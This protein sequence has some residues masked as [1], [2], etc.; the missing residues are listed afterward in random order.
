LIDIRECGRWRRIVEFLVGARIREP[1]RV[2]YYFTLRNT[3]RSIP[4][5]Q[6]IELSSFDQ[7]RAEVLQTIEEMWEEDPELAKESVG[8]NLDV[9]DHSGTVLLSISLG[10]SLI[11]GSKA[12]SAA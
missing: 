12:F 4:D 10:P 8:W 9:S 11:D 7:V 6:G 2:L 5:E 3:S 1:S